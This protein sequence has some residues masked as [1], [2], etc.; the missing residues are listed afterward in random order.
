MAAIG[1]ITVMDGITQGK[2]EG[3]CKRAGYEK[4]VEFHAFNH[5]MYIPTDQLSG[6]PTGQ[7]RHN[8]A[9]FRVALGKHSPKVMLACATGE[10]IKKVEAVFVRINEKGQEEVYLKIKL[11]NAIIIKVEHQKPFILDNDQKN[12]VDLED[13]SMTFAKIEME[14]V[15]DNVIAVDSWLDGSKT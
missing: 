9:I 3:E 4:A 13:I 8:P 7:R 2:L 12:W 11:E 15:K 5:S 14:A 1:Y 6:S 10:T